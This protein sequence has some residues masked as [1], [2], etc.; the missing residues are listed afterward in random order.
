VGGAVLAPFIS[1]IWSDGALFLMQYTGSQFVYNTSVAGLDCGL[2]AP[3]AAVTVDGFAYW[4]GSDNFYFYNGSVSPAPNVEDIRKYVFDAIPPNLA[5]Q[6]T[7]VYVP[8]FHEIWWFYPTSAT[9]NPEQYVIFHINDQCWSVGTGSFFSSSALVTTPLNRGPVA[10]AHITTAGSGF[11]NGLYFGVPL[12]GGT[13]SGAKAIITV[14]VSGVVSQVSI[15]GGAGQ[16]TLYTVGDV[17]T[18]AP[19][20]LGGSGSGFTCT[21]AFV[22]PCFVNESR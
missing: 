7:A 4:A 16:G 13:G 22:E 6:V 11:G 3:H 10:V 2:I 15:L 1:L 18:V 14:N 17:L 12:L 20:A 8:K 21:V 19:G 5:F 9:N